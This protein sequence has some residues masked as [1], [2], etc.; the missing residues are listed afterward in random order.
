MLFKMWEH[1]RRCHYEHYCI[2]QHIY[3]I[4][5]GELEKLNSYLYKIKTSVDSWASMV[6]FSPKHLRKV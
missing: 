6:M 2:Q 3:A 1:V 4:K 5:T